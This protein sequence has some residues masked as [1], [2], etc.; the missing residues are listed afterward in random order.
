MPRV[1]A[2]KRRRRT[3]RTK[4]RAMSRKQIIKLIHATALKDAETKVFDEGVNLLGT[5]DPPLVGAWTSQS[6]IIPTYQNVPKL[7]NTS[8][9]TDISAIGNEIQARG[10]KYRFY[11]RISSAGNIQ[12]I[13]FRLSLVSTSRP[14]FLTSAIGKPGFTPS[15]WYEPETIMPH[16]MKRFDNQEV[17]VLKSK[18]FYFSPYVSSFSLVKEV[19]FW[20]RIKGKKKLDSDENLITNSLVGNFKGKNYFVILEVHGGQASDLATSLAIQYDKVCYFKDP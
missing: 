4:R 16:T 10:V 15:A 17:N 14:D 11:M 20:C 7:K 9:T 6:F 18:V 12:Q 5:L 2:H 19:N 1:R 13:R 8:T 3:R